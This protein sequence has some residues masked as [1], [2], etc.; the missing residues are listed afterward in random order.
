P[1]GKCLAET[2]RALNTPKLPGLPPLTGGTVGSLSY[3]LVRQWHGLESQTPDDLQLPEVFL[4]LATD[5]V[6]MD[7]LDSS[8]WII[9]NA[10]N[11]DDT[12]ERVAQA[13][14]NAVERLDRMTAQLA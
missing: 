1:V 4:A 7:H 6:V 11:H 12:D 3:D 13:W 8:I 14:S 9:A 2:L 5:L 10:I